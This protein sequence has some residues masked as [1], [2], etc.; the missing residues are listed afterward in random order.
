MSQLR[1]LKQKKREENRRKTKRQKAFFQ[2]VFIL[3][4][5][6][7]FIMLIV[8]VINNA[9]TLTTTIISGI[10]WLLF[11]II[12][13]YAIKNKWSFLFDEC[14]T[15]RLSCDYTKTDSQRKR[16]NWQGNCL[17]FAISIII[18]IIHLVVL[19]VMF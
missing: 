19:F 11:D 5:I 15:G 12:F 14:S 16:D 4:I 6:I 17:Y 13:A 18:F 8:C 7:S 1:K 3:T 2:C 9:P 10:A